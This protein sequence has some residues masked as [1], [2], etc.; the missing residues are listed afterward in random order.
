MKKHLKT[1]FIGAGLV[2]MLLGS[3]TMN[4]AAS[5]PTETTETDD[6]SSTP[7]TTW[8]AS[9]TSDND[10]IFFSRKLLKQ[11]YMQQLVRS[12]ENAGITEIEG[13]GLKIDAKDIWNTWGKQEDERRVNGTYYLVDTAG[14]KTSMPTPTASG[15]GSAYWASAAYYLTITG[16]INEGG[17]ATSGKD[18]TDEQV[19]KAYPNAGDDLRCPG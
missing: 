19:M 7:R 5:S 6:S 9:P 2:L 11:D 4:V 3:M 1:L 15:D 17:Q 8:K 13:S 10:N 12:F 14:H 18:L 16:A